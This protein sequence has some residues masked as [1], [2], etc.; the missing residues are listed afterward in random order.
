[1]LCHY[2]ITL[3]C[4]DTCEFCLI[5]QNE[6]YS[7]IE[8]R[9]VDLSLFPRWGITELNVTGGEPLLRHDLPEILKQA[10]QLGLKTYLTTNGILY[11]EKAQ[12]LKGLI[13]ELCFS[14][15][16]P[17]PELHNRCRG[18]ECFDLVL[19]GL[20]IAKQLKERP[21]INFTMTRDS[22]MYLPE[23]VELAGTFGVMIKLTPVYD[24]SG[25]QGFE[26]G[27]FAHIN[28][29]ARQRHVLVN[30]AQLAM[31]K[32]LG[33]KTSLP[34][35]RAEQTTA[36]FLP[37]GRRVKPCLFNQEGVAGRGTPCSSCMRWDYMLPSFSLGFDKYYWLNRYSDYIN[38]R[39]MK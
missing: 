28:Y 13:D 36:T 18:E 23:M 29:Y 10:K 22:V 1:M 3:R 32:D 26:R 37:D 2:F 17:L 33:N 24:F 19:Q 7:K 20:K 31:V 11:S 15:D 9:P 8:E 34:R 5:W 38:W 27:T 4:N 30:L 39:K 14:L 25:T 35:C 21:I 16:Y 6:E 12:E